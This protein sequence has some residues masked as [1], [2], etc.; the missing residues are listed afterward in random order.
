MSAVAQMLNPMRSVRPR[1]TRLPADTD[2][3]GRSMRIQHSPARHPAEA[4]GDWADKAS[5][6][7]RRTW[8]WKG[9]AEAINRRQSKGG[10][11]QAQLTA[12]QAARLQDT[13]GVLCRRQV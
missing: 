8:T 5:L 3:S 6:P 2:V 7:H 11:R 1:M 13:G 10:S 9:A 4:G 12:A